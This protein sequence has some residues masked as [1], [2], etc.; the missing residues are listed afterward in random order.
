MVDLS[1]AT[2]YSVK[3]LKRYNHFISGL[4]RNHE[5]ELIL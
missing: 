5:H 3:V 4:A 1:V 2:T